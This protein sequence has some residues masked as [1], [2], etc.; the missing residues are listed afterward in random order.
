M[1]HQRHFDASEAALREA[2]QIR[3]VILDLDRLV[4]ILNCNIAT[5][6]ERVRV[7]DRS[8]PAYPILARTLAARRDNLL[9]TIAALEEHLTTIKAP[10]RSSSVPLPD[11][12]KRRV[13]SP[14]FPVSPASHC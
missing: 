14:F 3:K 4:Q 10:W 5:E 2:V 1:K 13:R 8:D 6:E 11:A 12:P 9:N 7:F